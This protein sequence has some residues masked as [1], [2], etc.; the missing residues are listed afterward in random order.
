[1]FHSRWLHNLLDL[2]R[3]RQERRPQAARQHRR[4]RLMLEALEDRITPSEATV[5]ENAP[6]AASLQTDLN[7]ATAA[8]TAYIINLTGD[9]AAYDLTVGQQLTISAVRRWRAGR[10]GSRPARPRKGA[11][12]TGRPA[13]HRAACSLRVRRTLIVIGGP[14]GGAP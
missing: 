12:A 14:S 4:V 2:S 11:G 3:S 8:D 13:P 9:S 5:T 1:M 6:N 10:R 7:N